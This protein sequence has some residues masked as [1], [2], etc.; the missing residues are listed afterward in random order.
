MPPDADDPS[1]YRSRATARTCRNCGSD[2]IIPGVHI[3]DETGSSGVRFLK[4]AVAA[5]PKAFW[6][7][8]RAEGHLVAVIC[9][10]CGFVEL[11]AE[12]ATQLYEAYRKAAASE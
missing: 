12:H 9:G 3:E 5:K 7:D 4:I 11:W 6:N 1:P 10:T 8:Q 2:K